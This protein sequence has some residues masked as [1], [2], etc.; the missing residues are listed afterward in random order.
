MADQPQPDFSQNQQY[1]PGFQAQQPIPGIS[2]SFNQPMQYQQQFQP[3]PMVAQQ[4]DMIAVQSMVNSRTTMQLAQQNLMSSMHFALAGTMGAFSDITR[5]G[6]AMVTAMSPVGKYNDMLAPNQ[7]WALESS[8]RREVGF[9]AASGMGLDPHTSVMSRMLQGRRPEFLTEGEYGSTMGYATQLRKASFEK[10][11][12]SIGAS[13]GLTMGASAL[14]LGLA[15]SIALPMVGGLIVDRMLEASHA[16]HESS[17]KYQLGAKTKRVGIGQQFMHTGEMSKVHQ[18]FYESE[19]PY[20]SRFLGDNAL[21]NAFKPD[22]QKLKIFDQMKDNGLMSFESLNADNIINYVNKIAST[23]E[24]FSRIGKVTREV[25]TKLMGDI[26]GVGIHGN[27]MISSFQTTAYESNLTGIDMQQLTGI[28]TNAAASVRMQ[29]FQSQNAFDSM[30][31]IISGFS[32]MQNAGSFRSKDVMQLSQGVFN[33]NASNARSAFGLISKFGGMEGLNRK[34]NDISPGN[35]PGG[36]IDLIT[37]DQKV[38]GLEAVKRDIERRRKEGRTRDQIKADI[39]SQTNDP[40]MAQLV[41]MI[42]FGADQ[43]GVV[44][45]NVAAY[46]RLKGQES[47][48]TLVDIKDIGAY[49]ESGEDPNQMQWATHFM[50]GN[51]QVGYDYNKILRKKEGGGS[52]AEGIRKTYE[53]MRG[54]VKTY[55]DRYKDGEVSKDNL[56]TI[57]F[58]LA[59]SVLPMDKKGYF[60]SDR[61]RGVVGEGET[62]NHLIMAMIEESRPGIWSEMQDTFNSKYNNNTSL[63]GRLTKM[64]QSISRSAFGKSLNQTAVGETAMGFIDYLTSQGK[65]NEFSSKLLEVGKAGFSSFNDLSEKA[66]QVL[67]GMGVDVEEWYKRFRGSGKEQDILG[68][69]S[70][71]EQVSHSYAGKRRGFE[72]KLIESMGFKKAN[73][74]LD[75]DRFEKTISP[76]REWRKKYYGDSLELLEAG[77]DPDGAG[78]ASKEFTRETMG[79]ITSKDKDVRMAFRKFMGPLEYDKLIQAYGKAGQMPLNIA[80]NMGPSI[81]GNNLAEIDPETVKKAMETSAKDVSADPSDKAVASLNTLLESIL[82]EMKKEKSP[83]ANS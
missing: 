83:K 44:S 65:R 32:M 69:V 49:K 79:L 73:G 59:T 34:M 82:K 22:V 4:A 13:A 9:M 2:S 11:L 31:Q 58:D 55:L 77:K 74:Q 3:N 27:D 38:G 47:M 30:G 7:N 42:W 23:V 35:T 81:G 29:G 26:K 8:F 12:M 18:S 46:K 6:G 25:A 54:K 64:K 61:H 5:R 62:A 68:V 70:G 57:V 76:L 56:D 14:G 80:E 67:S 63:A 17:I 53:E 24:K 28:K 33:Y 10:G 78:V 16:E 37:S 60:K 50:G 39:Y 36:Y 71:L 45:Q 72:L 52:H 48:P 40:Q 21:G 66:A 51:K 20:I 75:F 19:N 15:S 41:D 1:A 43:V